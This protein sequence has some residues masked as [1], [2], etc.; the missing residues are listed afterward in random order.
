MAD[1]RVKA[2]ARTLSRFGYGDSF[3]DSQVRAP[4]GTGVL[5]LVAYCQEAPWDLRTSAFACDIA[6]DSVRETRVLDL[7][8]QVAAPFA[9]I[10]EASDVLLFR[11]GATGDGDERLASVGDPERALPPEMVRALSPSAIRAAKYGSRQL[12]LFPIDVRLLETARQRS[13][14]TLTGRVH[15]AYLQVHDRSGLDS[16]DAARLVIGALAAIIVR[17]KYDLAATEPAQIIDAVMARHGSYFESLAGHEANSPDV[18]AAALDQLSSGLDYSAVDA[19]TINKVYENLLVTPDVRRDLGIFYTPPEFASRVVETLPIET[20]APADRSVFD[21]ACGSGNLLLAAIERLELLMPGG[22]SA[23]DAHAWLNTHVSGSDVDPVAT[24]IARLSMLVSS[25]PLGNNWQ[26]ETRNVIENPPSIEPTIIVSNPPWRNP[27]G[28]R[29][30]AATE[31]LNRSVESLAPGGLLACVLPGTWLSTTTARAG[32]RSLADNCELFEVWRLPRDLFE[33]A[34]YG[35]AVVFCRKTKEPKR[36]RHAF[37]WVASGAQRRRAFL[38]DGQ[39]TFSWLAPTPEPGHAL[40]SGPLDVLHDRSTAGL[41]KDVA[42]VVSGVVQKGEPQAVARGQHLALLRGT[43]YEPYGTTDEMPTVRIASGSDFGAGDRDLSP[44][45]SPQVLVQAH[46]NPDTEWRVRPVLDV[47]G[48]VPSNAWHAVV[49][50]RETAAEARALLALLA[51]SAASIWVHSHV[52]TKN[53]PKAAIE[54]LPLPLDWAAI[55]D[56]LAD[57]GGRLVSG[58]DKPATLAE[59][60]TVVADGYKLTRRQRSEIH[61]VMATSQAPEGKPRFSVPPRRGPALVRPS[62]GPTEARPGAVLAMRGSKLQIWALGGPDE[63]V[64]LELPEHLPGWLAA[65]GA[66]FDVV[67]SNLADAEYHF[68]R[69]SHRSEGELFGLER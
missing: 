38:D 24:E 10:A 63:G 65:E 1:A 40:T 67:G 64:R 68:H 32:R 48:V 42:D 5:E 34:R 57:L 6:S 22:W 7:A 15:H 27:K 45:R 37:R 28:S 59:I 31:F 46:R 3:C 8:R 25:L 69:A 66:V 35:S 16:G 9:L 20:I 62:D 12:S 29:S 56:T 60:E 17:D 47:R 14:E 39:T 53:I 52:A 36:S 11:V 49:G 51:S 61:A 13:V 50:K 55:S 33:E 18:V 23:N 43:P 44:F 41:L 54:N 4:D 19:R 21:P 58:K 26:I 2:L 30:E